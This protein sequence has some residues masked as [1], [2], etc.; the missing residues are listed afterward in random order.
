MMLGHTLGFLALG[1]KRSGLSYTDQDRDLVRT[2]AR[3]VRERLQAGKLEGEIERSR[4]EQARL[5][6]LNRAKSLFVSSVTHDLKTPLTSIRLYAEMMSTG[7]ENEQHL[8]Y[9]RIIEGES[10]RLTRLIDQ[11]LSF[12]RIERGIMEYRRGTCDVNQAV[13]EVLDILAY[14]FDMAKADVSVDLDPS[15]STIPADADAL[16]NAV[17]NVLS[18][19]LKYAR[20][21]PWVR[22]STAMNGASVEI[23]VE[24]H[25]IGISEEHVRDL[26]KPFMR[27]DQTG[28]TGVAGTGIGLSTVHHFLHA[29]GGELRIKSTPDV[30][31][32]FTLVL[33]RERTDSPSRGS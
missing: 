5:E 11:V 24:D 6:E 17:M 28:E 27:V 2:I 10:E 18:N 21:T 4:I 15:V 20:E 23:S 29:H 16:K 3:H 25:G 31:S 12:S 22:V 32:T 1:A 14:Q 9:L 7:T 30:G 26:H 19:A 33:P 13:E 8:K